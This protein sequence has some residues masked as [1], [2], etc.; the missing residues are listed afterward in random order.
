MGYAM[1]GASYCCFRKA[2]LL[3][4]LLINIV[5]TSANFHQDLFLLAFF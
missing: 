2:V 1:K 3:I 5:S 4:L